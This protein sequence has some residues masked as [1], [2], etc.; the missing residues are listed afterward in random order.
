VEK[1]RSVLSTIRFLISEADSNYYSENVNEMNGTGMDKRTGLVRAS[2]YVALIFLYTFVLGVP[3]LIV[4]LFNPQ[5]EAGYWFIRT[6][7]RLL[8]WTCGVKIKLSGREN[9]PSSGP[10]ILMATHNSHFDIPILI[11]EVPRQFRIVAKKSLFKIPIFGW[12]MSAAGYVSVDRENKQQAFASLDKASST[13]KAGMPLLI[14]PEGTRSPDGSLGPFKKGGF[15]LAT[16]AKAPII[17]VVIDGTYHVLP[18][19][20][21]RISPG[22]VR[23]TLGKPIDASGYSYETKESLMEDVHKAMTEIRAANTLSGHASSLTPSD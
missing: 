12:I 16:K 18:K 17:P 2:L 5:G 20:T 1:E 19:S 22:S 13:V 8:L 14:F 9:L 23:V 7:A 4:T 21:W 11:K 15:V 6:W 3:C 10:F